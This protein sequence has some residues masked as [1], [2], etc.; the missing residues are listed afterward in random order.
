MAWARHTEWLATR[1]ELGRRLIPATATVDVVVEG[2]HRYPLR[3][4]RRSDGR[5]DVTISD[6]R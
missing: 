2:T 4:E 1:R 5:V 6:E 3:I